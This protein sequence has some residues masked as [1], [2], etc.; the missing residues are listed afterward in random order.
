VPASASTFSVLSSAQVMQPRR[1][2]HQARRPVR[3]ALLAAGFILG[4]IP[5]IA[6]FPALGVEGTLA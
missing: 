2:P 5:R 6:G 4:R 1:Q 3:L